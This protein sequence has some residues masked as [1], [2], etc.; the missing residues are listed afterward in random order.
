MPDPIYGLQSRPGS[1][2]QLSRFTNGWN[3]NKA[4][5]MLP[6]A[7]QDYFF[8]FYDFQEDTINSDWT[9]NESNAAATV[10]AASTSVEGGALVGAVDATD[11]RTISLNYDGVF[12][13]AN[14]SP[15]MLI[16]MKSSAATDV[17]LEFSWM[18]APTQPYT[19][20]WAINTPTL[21][22]NGTN[23]VA[24]I[25]MDTDAT[26]KTAVLV[27][28]GTTD[29]TAA[30][31][32]LA[33]GTGVGAI[34][35]VADTY[36]TA[37]LQINSAASATAGANSVSGCINGNPQL[38]NSLSVGLDT[39]IK[40]RPNII[41]GNRSTSARTFTIDYVSIWCNRQ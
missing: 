24:S 20:N 5:F 19:I 14:R 2:Q 7:F 26:Q 1:L 27:A 15:G 36:F 21:Q 31:R 11:N 4:L 30:K 22:S 16:R 6:L 8:K 17:Y 3:D 18:D 10:F 35:I 9:V 39:A 41:C 13:D 23:D 28:Q 29:S 40:I 25:V 34:P 12:F 33:E 37:L 32:N 38:S